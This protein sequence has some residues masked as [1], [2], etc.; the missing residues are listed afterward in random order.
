MHSSL[1]QA[2]CFMEIHHICYLDSI[3][4]YSNGNLGHLNVLV[5]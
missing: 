3:S 1:G 2:L 5:F 4:F